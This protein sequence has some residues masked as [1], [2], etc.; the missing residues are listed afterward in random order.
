MLR[1]LS[2]LSST[3]FKVQPIG[4]T[5]HAHFFGRP[6]KEPKRTNM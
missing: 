6:K 1:A 5:R 2:Q 3:A 4:W